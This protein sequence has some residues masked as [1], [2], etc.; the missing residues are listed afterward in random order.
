MLYSLRWQLPPCPLFFQ[1]ISQQ[2]GLAT[3]GNITCKTFSL[4]WLHPLV[5][6][7]SSSFSAHWVMQIFIHGFP[8]S[9]LVLLAK[10]LGC[11]YMKWDICEHEGSQWKFYSCKNFACFQHFTLVPK[12]QTLRFQSCTNLIIR[13][14]GHW[15]NNCFYLWYAHKLEDQQ[16]TQLQILWTLCKQF[17]HNNPIWQATQTSKCVPPRIIL[18]P[19]LQA[20]ILTTFL[21]FTK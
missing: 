15:V 7:T 1:P 21:C 3:K 10:V 16:C 18:K 5:Q 14:F 2:G 4:L 12:F 17:E 13:L 6:T 11:C 9:K 20:I 8:L 19:F